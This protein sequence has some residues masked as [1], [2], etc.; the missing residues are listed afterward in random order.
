MAMRYPKIS[1][2]T[3][4]YN[5][6]GYINKTIESVIDQKY[7][8]WEHIIVDDG[9][10]DNSVEVIKQYVA[11][12]PHNI[13]LICQKNEGQ[14][15]A[16]NKGFACVTG[17]I[18]GW[19]NADDLYTSKSFYTVADILQDKDI[20]AVYSNCL[21][22]DKEGN[23]LRKLDT[24]RP[25]KWLALFYCFIPSNTFFFRREIIDSGITIDRGFHITMDKEFFAHI[26]YD[27]YN[28]KY[29]NNYLASFRLHEM[30]KSIDSMEVQKIRAVEG[31]RLINKTM[32]LNLST[33][34]ITLKLYKLLTFSAGVY[35]KI[36]KIT[37]LRVLLG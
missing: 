9:S 8:D 32:R 23:L 36:I 31:I 14:S 28:V 18:I 33:N 13:K 7:P 20:D 6:A 15:D 35:R 22:I 5:Y 21:I 10:T 34:M 2:V 25:I 17:E 4:S 29:V 1:I 26:L 30:N 12:Y 24:H 19:L 16:I 27:K 11:M 3:P 37:S